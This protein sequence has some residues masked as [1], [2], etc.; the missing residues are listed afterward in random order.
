MQGLGANPWLAYLASWDS[1]ASIVAEMPQNSLFCT[2]Y[3]VFQ[4]I[5]MAVGGFFKARYDELC[6]LF[7]N[8]RPLMSLTDAACDKNNKY[9]RRFRKWR[10]RHCAITRNDWFTIGL[11]NVS[12]YLFWDPFSKNRDAT[13]GLKNIPSDFDPLSHEVFRTGRFVICLIRGETG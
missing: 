7:G 10:Y 6:N 2:I 11:A 5:I 13:P 8:S 4:R 3:G 9:R 12:I 1:T